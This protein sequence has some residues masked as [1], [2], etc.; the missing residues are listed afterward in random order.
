MRLC[1][2]YLSEPSVKKTLKNTL[3]MF[4]NTARR[5]TR[6]LPRKNRFNQL[7]VYLPLQLDEV[8][9]GISLGILTYSGSAPVVKPYFTQNS[10]QV[11][12]SASSAN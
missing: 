8:D 12:S 1:S 10:S 3:I 11:I 4:S 2:T 5:I 6:K 9:Y 7:Y